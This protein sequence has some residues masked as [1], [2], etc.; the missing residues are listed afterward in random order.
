MNESDI[1]VFRLNHCIK[2]YCSSYYTDVL[3]EADHYPMFTS[4][5]N[6]LTV[7]EHR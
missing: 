3:N 4:V 1:L 6:D 5:K 2:T 7:S